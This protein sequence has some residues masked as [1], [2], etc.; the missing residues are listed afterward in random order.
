MGKSKIEWTDFTWNPVTGCTKVSE[1]CKN[2]YAERIAKRFW[3]DRE[4]SE[5]RVHPERLGEIDRLKD[6]Q[7][8]FVCSMS[9]LFHPVVPT[10]FILDVWDEMVSHPRHTFIVL[11]KR[12]DR[13]RRFS[14]YYGSEFSANNI[15]LGVSAENK[16]RANER[17]PILINTPAA[18]RFVSVEPMLEYVTMRWIAAW[19]GKALNPDNPDGR[20]NELD[21]LRKLSWIICGAESGPG[22]RPFEESWARLLKNQCVAANVPFFYKQGRV[23]GKLVKMPELDGRVW[24]QYPE[25]K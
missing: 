14:V 19:N 22:A 6:P 23:D 5:V 9:D 13:M 15:W 4:F 25:A 21:G 7:K 16:K 20:T 1:G 2:C 24:D 8:I 10:S 18:V 3:K 17:I 11:T 12:P